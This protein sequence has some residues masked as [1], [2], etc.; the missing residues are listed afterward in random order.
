MY[1]Y[2]FVPLGIRLISILILVKAGIFIF[3][4]EIIY[5]VI[6]SFNHLAD[7]ASGDI[8]SNVMR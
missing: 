1:L 7:I 3:F 4:S 5:V 8:C 2:C 6:A